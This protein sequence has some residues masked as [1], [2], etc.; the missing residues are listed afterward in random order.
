[1]DKVD[2]AVVGAGV[3]GLAVACELAHRGREVVVI[4]R[5]VSIGMETS[6]RNSKVIHAALYY[7]TGSLRAQFIAKHAA[8]LLDAQTQEATRKSITISPGSLDV[9]H[10]DAR[11]NVVV[12]LREQRQGT[13][14]VAESHC[15]RSRASNAPKIA[16][17]RKR[18]A[19]LCASNE[20]MPPETSVREQ[21]C[22]MPKLLKLNKL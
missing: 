4:E 6:S 8:D 3:I 13:M 7:P 12:D 18:F 21:S 15:P 9:S 2:C 20:Y 1:M 10:L 11:T 14:I 22:A 16:A 5:H 19:I 17:C